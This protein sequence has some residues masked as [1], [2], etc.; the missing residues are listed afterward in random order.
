[1]TATNAYARRSG[2]LSASTYL[3]RSQARRR[4][5]TLAI[6]GA[7]VV[8]VAMYFVGYGAGYR[9]AEYIDAVLR[10][11]DC[12]QTWRENDTIWAD[13]EWPAPNQYAS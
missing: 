3:S 13:D 7:M 6:I 2:I 4:V 11:A 12:D 1:M 9:E 10:E 8:G 5:P